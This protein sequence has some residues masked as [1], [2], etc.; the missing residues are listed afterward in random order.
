M[1]DVGSRLI[2]LLSSNA[3]ERL[4]E[5]LRSNAVKEAD[6]P[7]PIKRREKDWPNSSYQTRRRVVGRR[8]VSEQ[9]AGKWWVE[10]VEVRGDL[11]ISIEYNLYLETRNQ[12]E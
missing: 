1:S 2:D 5:L 4:A 12:S 7:P 8:L 3:K 10:T 6:Q 11:Q 9:R